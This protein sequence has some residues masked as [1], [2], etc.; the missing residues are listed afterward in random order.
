MEEGYSKGYDSGIKLGDARRLVQIIDSA[1]LHFGNNLELT[2][3]TLNVTAAEY[4]NAKQ[5]ISNT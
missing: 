4:E 1:L 3:K 2:C 5:L